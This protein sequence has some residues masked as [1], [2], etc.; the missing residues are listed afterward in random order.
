MRNLFFCFDRN[1]SFHLSF[2]SVPAR[3]KAAYNS[4]A[5]CLYLCI[6]VYADNFATLVIY[7]F[8]IL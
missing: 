5:I 1:I 8:R 7:F 3:H 6:Y 4:V 2:V